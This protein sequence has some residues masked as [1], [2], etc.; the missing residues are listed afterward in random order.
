MRC[1]HA[2]LVAPSIA[3]SYVAGSVASQYPSAVDTSTQDALHI[4]FVGHHIAPPISTSI[5]G[6]DQD[7]KYL[8]NKAEACELRGLR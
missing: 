6:E 1:S 4:E 7:L 2:S 8:S 5:N 3:Y